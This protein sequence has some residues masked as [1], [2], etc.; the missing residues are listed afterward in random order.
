MVGDGFALTVPAG[1]G[2]AVPIDFAATDGSQIAAGILLRAA[3]LPPGID[4]RLPV[5]IRMAL[6]AASQL[7]WPTGATGP[8]KA[9]ALD[10]LSR[11]GILVREEA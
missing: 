6:I 11:A 4:T 7:V 10:Q 2:K 1:D 3:T 5:L 8:Q 9:Q